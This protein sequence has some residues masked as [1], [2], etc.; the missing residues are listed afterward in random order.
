MTPPA[1]DPNQWEI[2]PALR[3]VPIQP[4]SSVAGLEICFLLRLEPEPVSGAFVLIRQT[5]NATVVLGCLR[6]AG[7][8]VVEWLELY[9][10]RMLSEVAFNPLSKNAVCNR[11][12][13]L[14][15]EAFARD[16]EQ[17]DPYG[18]VATPWAFESLRPVRVSLNGEHC[19]YLADADGAAWVLCRDTAV[20][21]ALGEGS[22]G[23]GSNRYLVSVAPDRPPRLARVHSQTSPSQ[24]MPEDSQWSVPIDWVVQPDQQGQ[25]LF[26][27]APRL[28][29][30]RLAPVSLMEYLQLL[31]GFPWRG[32]ENSKAPVLPSGIYARLAQAES[33]RAGAAH[34]LGGRLGQ[35]G[36]LLE[37]LQLKL[38]AFK[39]MLEAVRRVTKL[40]QVPHLNLNEVSF[41][42][43]F[44]QPVAQLPL[45]WSAQL[46]L[47][48]PGAAEAIVVPGTAVR[49]FQ[50]RTT[51]LVSVYQPE[52]MNGLL[53]GACS[54]RILRT[55]REE[56]GLVVD[57]TVVF[58]E[59]AGLSPNSLVW[60]QLPVAPATLE[61]YGYVS[62]A[63][64]NVQGELAFRSLPLA[65]EKALEEKLGAAAGATLNHLPFA[66]LPPV[67]SPVDLYA[68]AVLASRM[69]L[70]NAQTSLPLALDAL[71]KLGATLSAPR[72]G[73]LPGEPAALGAHIAQLV[74]GDPEWF[75][76][77]GPH[78]L[79][80][81]TRDPEEALGLMPGQ[82]WWDLLALLVKM[83]PGTLPFGFCRDLG[84]APEAALHTIYDEPL[85][86]I[87]RL[88]GRVRAALFG[89]WAS[90]AEIGRL[91]QRAAEEL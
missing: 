88:V 2:P 5:L 90:N 67:S 21:S 23:E 34:L 69:F 56:E 89:D 1:P 26:W 11:Q 70:V 73:T 48:E 44:G 91:I 71:L 33:L 68:L 24:T 63:A 20:L 86:E 13:D 54:F 36:M 62:R 74:R 51:G 87:D 46:S 60:I 10:Q 29:V 40:R 59:V 30:R 15:W 42:V 65:L 18:F 38:M 52:A 7:G 32:I 72:S 8:R 17:S 28:L 58:R 79:A 6:D 22:Y 16:T 37:V 27:T 25:A 57:A 31:D 76:G 78:R 19:R 53:H 47:T 61:L 45:L 9:L 4:A 39:Q 55:T 80:S 3:A 66:M 75:A 49:V 50:K 83:F 12:W 82:I 43:R 85:L 77:L 81:E 41:A 35:T 64:G 14:E 84:D